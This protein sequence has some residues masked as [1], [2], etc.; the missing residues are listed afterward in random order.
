MSTGLAADRA[1]LRQ[2][3]GNACSVLKRVGVVRIEPERV[4]RRRLLT[5]DGDVERIPQRS[6]VGMQADLTLRHVRGES[7]YFV[8][9]ANPAVGDN[10]VSWVDH[11]SR[12][13]VGSYRERERVVIS[14]M[15]SG[16][17]HR[18]SRAAKRNAKDLPDSGFRE[19]DIAVIRIDNHA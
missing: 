10:T 13:G 12:E 9:T 6:I 2:G 7:P 15:E 3:I 4:R 16:H 19:K 11:S 18:S 17:P 1:A 8:G 14:R 5:R